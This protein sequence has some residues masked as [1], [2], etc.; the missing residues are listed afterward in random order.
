MGDCGLRGSDVGQM[1]PMPHLGVLGVPVRLQIAARYTLVTRRGLPRLW[2]QSGTCSDQVCARQAR[3]A[4]GS[5]PEIRRRMGPSNIESKTAFCV[6][7]LNI[8]TN[9][10]A[11]GVGTY[12]RNGPQSQ[13]FSCRCQAQTVALAKLQKQI[14]LLSKM[15]TE[16]FE[17]CISAESI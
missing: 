15:K 11:V 8:F 13:M 16:I 10:G 12:G 1:R 2:E 3:C 4:F 5:Y 7:K 9:L 17:F 14:H 6:R